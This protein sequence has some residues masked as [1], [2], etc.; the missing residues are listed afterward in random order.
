MFS[1]LWKDKLLAVSDS[2][3]FDP[4][5]EKIYPGFAQESDSYA[6]AD[7]HRDRFYKKFE[8]GDFFAVMTYI[9]LKHRLP[10]L[11]LTR[12]DKMTMAASIEARVPFLDHKLVEF[13]LQV[14]MKL[15]Y[16][17]KE[18]K[19]I[20]KKAAEGIV[21]HEVIYRK[22]VGFSAPVTHWFKKGQY[23]RN[24]LADM[25]HSKT[26]WHD[27]LNKEEI[28][29]LLKINRHSSVDYSYQLWAL[30]NIMAF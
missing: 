27:F 25:V 2:E 21:P 3:P 6:I 29:R 15:K 22:K 8:S 4:I 12:T 10:E 1:P 9:E 13:M 26:I 16:Q 30:Q 7:Y 23:F 11:L 19:Y 24:Y 28:D 5:I 20:L 18:T 17:K 14:P